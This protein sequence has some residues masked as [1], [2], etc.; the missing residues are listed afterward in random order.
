MEH[1]KVAASFLVVLLA[2]LGGGFVISY[3]IYQPQISSLTSEVAKLRTGFNELESQLNSLKF[4]ISNST[5]Q[6]KTPNITDIT[7]QVEEL[8]IRF[9]ILR[10]ALLNLTEIME[11]FNYILNILLTSQALSSSE[12]LDFLATQAAN[13]GAEFT[14][15]ITVKNVGPSP[16][17]ITAIFFNSVSY[18]NITGVSISPNPS[19]SILAI[20]A[21]GQ[22]TF[23]IKMPI[24]I[25]I[26]DSTTAPGA[27][28]DITIQTITGNRYTKTI[29][30]P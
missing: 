15:N 29:N 23:T 6:P 20:N 17:I 26:G 25:K 21:N 18:S 14:I 3:L 1:I 16:A 13:N 8:Q 19:T 11:D 7:S 27:S 4:A 5:G 24:N 9:E 12:R 22:Q 2:G 30:L 10:N 28:L